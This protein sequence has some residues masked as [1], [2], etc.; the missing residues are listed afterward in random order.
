MKVLQLGPFP[1]PYGGIQ[2]HLVAVRD[3]L[4]EQ[5]HSCAVV[6]ITRHRK[7]EADQVYYPESATQLLAHLF[8]NRY[9]IVH[10]HIGG[11]L[12]L[13]VLALALSCTTVPWAKAILTFHSGGYPSS[14]EGQ[15]AKKFSLRG[16]TFRRF[17]G[18]IGVNQEIIRFFSKLGVAEQQSRLIYPNAVSR[19]K[20]A[21]HLPEPLYSFFAAHDQ[22]LT[23]VC[24]LE[25]EYDLSRQIEALALILQRRPRTGLVILGSGSLEDKL[26]QQIA[27]VPYSNHIL[28]CGDVPHDVT[29][30][31]I[32]ESCALLRTTLYDGDAISVREALHLGT[33]VI[34]TDNGMR[35]QG[36]E[37]IPVSDTQA[38]VPAVFRVLENGR[39]NQPQP[40]RDDEN[41]AAVLNFYLE[42][43]DQRERPF[44][45]ELTSNPNKHA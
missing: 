32:V 4:R 18:L 12:P 30:R 9:D 14:R 23:A 29:L 37:L 19:A 35:P 15:S 2:T 41:L 5:G 27:A 38:L 10:L 1:P 33:P 21:D 31:A 28:M 11:M 8:R 39:K 43:L 24:L 3:Y 42:V 17:D 36:V 25:P 7:Q 6:N 22:I 26:R 40:A 13:R 44:T 34:A 16:F 20:I 45:P